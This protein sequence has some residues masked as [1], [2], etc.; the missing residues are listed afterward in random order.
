MTAPADADAALLEL[1]ADLARRAAAAIMA[2]RAAGFAV[3]RKA[4]RSPV[5]EADRI[6]EALIVEGLRAATPDIPVVAE[7][8]VEAGTAPTP[9]AAARLWLVDPLDGTREFAAGR[10]AFT[11][12]IGLVA[13]RRAVLGAVAVPATGEL[14]GGIV[15][16]GAWKEEAG[17]PR[18]PI[19]VRSPPPE[20]L[21][22]MASRHYADDPRL[23]AFLA[24]RRVARVV[25]IGSA[26]KFCRIAEGAADLYP[27]FGPTSEW[28]TAAPQAV[29]EAAGGT[30][31]R[32]EAA[33]G[34]L[35]YGKPGWENPAF[36]CTGADPAA[37]R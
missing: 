1:A 11:V 37:A 19:A 6:A 17:G 24:G 20:G 21:T 9:D 4:D 27:R 10:E 31:R 35:L 22:V 14:F 29:L 16:R 7:E 5:T 32:L 8:E 3:A 2:V 12:N 28:D 36:V 30:V 25:H 26:V 13:A 33:G 23:P 18:R 34:P 15:G